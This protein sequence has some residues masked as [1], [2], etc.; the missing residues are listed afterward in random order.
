MNNRK[1]TLIELLVVIAIIAILASMLLPALQQARN[2]AK[3]TKC[4]SNLKQIG[5]YGLMYYDQCRTLPD[6]DGNLGYYRGKWADMLYAMFA[7]IEATG[8]CSTEWKE[9]GN[10]LPRGPFACPSSAAEDTTL[11]STHYGINGHNCPQAYGSANGSPGFNLGSVKF[12]S[13][14]S[15]FFDINKHAAGAVAVGRNREGTW[16]SMLLGAEGIMKHRGGTGAFVTYVDGHTGFAM[17]QEIPPENAIFWGHDVDYY[18][19]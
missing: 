12:P 1:F 13:K 17:R 18:L 6:Y 9:G 19:Q 8:G 4:T 5:M 3:D 2:R 14:R 16:S 10:G 7:G 11:H 15:M